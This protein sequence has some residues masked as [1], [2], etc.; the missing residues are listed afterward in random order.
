MSI[1]F[2]ARVGDQTFACGQSYAGQGT[3]TLDV[4]PVPPAVAREWI[5]ASDWAA[6]QILARGAEYPVTGFGFRDRLF[7]PNTIQLAV[8]NTVGYG[9]A[10]PQISPLEAG[11]TQ[12]DY[13]RWLT[14]E[15]HTLIGSAHNACMVFTATGTYNEFT[16]VV[17]PEAMRRAVQSTGFTE[18]TT[19]RLPN[20]RTATLWQRPGKGC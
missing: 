16:P 9:V 19:R 1:P 10:M 17:D 3:G 2:A 20:G 5:A 6:K 7:N 12:A 15:S 14:E 13:E 18:V 11:D 8:L 4:E